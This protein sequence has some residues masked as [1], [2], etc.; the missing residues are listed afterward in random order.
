MLEVE[1]STSYPLAVKEINV[2]DQC[3]LPIEHGAEGYKYGIGS[4]YGTYSGGAHWVGANTS[5]SSP[6]IKE[7]TVAEKCS[8]TI[9]HEAQGCKDDTGPWYGTYSDGV[10]WVG[11]NFWVASKLSRLFQEYLK[12]ED[13]TNPRS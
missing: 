3:S 7:I 4:W 10:H 9:E 11:T 5:A 12:K 8:I 2:V 1:N 6:D 13:L